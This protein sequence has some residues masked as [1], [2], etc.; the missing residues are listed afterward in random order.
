MPGLLDDPQLASLLGITPQVIGQPQTGGGLLNAIQTMAPQNVGPQQ[1]PA[2]PQ[3]TAAPSLLDRLKGGLFPSG[4]AG[5]LLDP[6]Q[7]KQLRD[8]QMLQMGLS[9]LA[10]SGPKPQGTSSPI[11][12]VAQ[13]VLGATSGWPQVVNQAAE[14]ATAVRNL[15]QGQQRRT[16]IESIVDKYPAAPGESQQQLG[17]RIGHMIAD[18]SRY[19][20][21]PEGNAFLTQ[22]STLMKAL[23]SG[24][25]PDL[26]FRMQ[27][28]AQ[29]TADRQAAYQRLQAL[30]IVPKSEAFTPSKDYVKMEEGTEAPQT[31]LVRPEGQPAEF[32]TYTRDGRELSR[33]PTGEI[34]PFTPAHVQAGSFGVQAYK[35]AMD[36]RDTPQSLKTQAAEWVALGKGSKILPFIKR[37][38]D[39]S[40]ALAMAGAPDE[41]QAYWAKLK[42]LAL[43]AA[44]AIYGKGIRSPSLMHEFLN[45]YGLGVGE[46][47]PKVAAAKWGNIIEALQA[48]KL[49]A[50]GA[51]DAALQEAG[52]S[53]NEIDLTGGRNAGTYKPKYFQQP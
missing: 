35:D 12:G 36:I 20:G 5:G 7:L 16:A 32:V 37:G 42:H 28:N 39:L 25:T 49:N 34:V 3:P 1:P 14:A 9:L 48:A 11:S 18:A 27:Q 23:D 13:S 44:P 19:A 45:T 47:G 38:E 26:K 52:L 8:Q 46:T 10:N 4:P 2:M 50:G 33:T 31:K 51:W 43:M 17:A 30:G 6:A 24:M 41:V 21:T 22:L 53:G 40:D 15:Q 29:Q